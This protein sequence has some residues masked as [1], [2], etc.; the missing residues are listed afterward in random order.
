ME[1]NLHISILY[2]FSSVVLLKFLLCFYKFL[3]LSALHF[4]VILLFSMKWSVRARVCCVIME[5][6]VPVL[7]LKKILYTSV[8]FFPSNQQNNCKDSSSEF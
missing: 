1:A 5:V 4:S 7:G 3:T 8:T 6:Q 2:L